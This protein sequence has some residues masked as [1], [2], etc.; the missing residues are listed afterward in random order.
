MS[1]GSI[2][3]SRT[4]PERTGRITEPTLA[5]IAQGT[6][7]T[8][9]NGHTFTYSAGQFVIT[10]VELPVVAHIVQASAREP[11][12]AFVLSL[13]PERIAALLLE[14]TPAP[15]VRP[16]AVDAAPAGFAVSEAS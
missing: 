10:S 14:T 8:A 2:P 1:G 15:T 3:C 11:F 13:R 6:K 12:L 5:V 9:L 4:T 7:E 16:R